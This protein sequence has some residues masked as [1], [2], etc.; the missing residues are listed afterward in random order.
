MKEAGSDHR[1][2]VALMGGRLEN[3]ALRSAKAV[4]I[5]QTDELIDLAKMNLWR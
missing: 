3:P 1:A 4:M 2:R 5:G